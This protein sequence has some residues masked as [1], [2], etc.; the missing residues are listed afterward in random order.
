MNLYMKNKG[1]NKKTFLLFNTLQLE[2]K[3]EPPTRQ[4]RQVHHLERVLSDLRA[5]S[6]SPVNVGSFHD[7]RL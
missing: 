4:K 3:G 6:S 1:K 5:A 2:C 7:Y